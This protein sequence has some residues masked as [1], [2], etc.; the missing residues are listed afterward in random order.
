MEEIAFAMTVGPEFATEILKRLGGANNF[1]NIE[2]N[3]SKQATITVHVLDDRSSSPRRARTTPS[4]A[5]ATCT[6]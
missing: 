2:V 5:P 4:P 6:T 3:T 1:A